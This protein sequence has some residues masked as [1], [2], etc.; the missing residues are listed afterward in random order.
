[1]KGT[2]KMLAPVSGQAVGIADVHDPM[3][4]EKAMGEGY[5]VIPN[6]QEV[7][8]PVSGK[9][10]LVASTKHAVGIS[11]DDGLEVLV[12]MGVDTVELNGAPF[13]LFVKEGDTVKAGQKIATMDIDAVKKAGKVTDV[14]VAIT[15]TAK[16][17]KEIKV[18]SG[19]VKAG[20]SVAEVEM[21]APGEAT[22]KPNGKVDYNELGK[23]LLK[24]SVE[25]VTSRT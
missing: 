5:G 14:I 17:V 24:M 7:V 22:A 6:S 12:H 4:S 18:D 19:E 20:D 21:M 16:T 1:M 15:N 25:Q 2:V 23:K 9:I 8:A 13:N 10:M 3:F 11:T